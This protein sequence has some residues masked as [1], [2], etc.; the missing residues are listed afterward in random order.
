MSMSGS[1]RRG[2]NSIEI[3]DK[4]PTE[5]M[6]EDLDGITPD[7]DDWLRSNVRPR[8]PNNGRGC[9]NRSKTASSAVAAHPL[10]L[11]RTDAADRHTTRSGSDWQCAPMRRQDTRPGSRLASGSSTIC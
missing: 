2:W 4:P 6:F 9:N 8:R 5:Q 10:S 7:F 3:A 1:T 11:D